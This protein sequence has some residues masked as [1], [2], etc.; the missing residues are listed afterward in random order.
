[1]EGHFCRE[2]KAFIQSEH[3]S[4]YVSPIALLAHGGLPSLNITAT[5]ISWH[6]DLKP[7]PKIDR[8][9]IERPPLNVPEASP[10]L[11]NPS[12]I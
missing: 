7:V 6:S 4:P 10:T 2:R 12:V 1:M 3:A 9:E 8:Q 11:R 5:N